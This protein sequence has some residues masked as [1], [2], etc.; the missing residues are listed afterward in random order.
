V[1]NKSSIYTKKG[2]D[3]STQLVGGAKVEKSDKR[4]SLYGQ[5]DELNSWVGVV[6]AYDIEPEIDQFLEDLQK[7][8]FS[9]GAFLACEPS[10]RASLKISSISFEFVQRIEGEIDFLDGACSKLTK[11]V[12]PGGSKAA[13]FFHICRVNCR[14]LERELNFVKNENYINS[15][16]LSFTNRLSDYFFVAARYENIKKG[17]A[18]VLWDGV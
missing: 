3:G 17:N 16:I 2:D 9:L 18:E 1:T 11:F 13:S 14:K 7:E 6:R 4:V 15:D 8:L 5:V 12:L 10:K